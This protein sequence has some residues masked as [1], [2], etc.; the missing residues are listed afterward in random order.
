MQNPTRGIAMQQHK[1]PPLPA[2]NKQSIHE[3]GN[4]NHS[5]TIHNAS[6][7]RVAIL[8]PIHPSARHPPSCHCKQSIISTNCAAVAIIIIVADYHPNN[9]NND[10]KY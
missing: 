4:N 6:T 2:L 7:G 3:N 10:G 9:N 1:Q 8:L 5:D